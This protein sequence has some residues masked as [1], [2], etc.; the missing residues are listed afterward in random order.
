MI[1]YLIDQ[2]IDPAICIR[3][4]MNLIGVFVSWLWN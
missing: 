1:Q 4:G 3:K 2:L